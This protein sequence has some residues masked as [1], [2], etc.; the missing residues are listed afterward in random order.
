MAELRFPVRVRYGNG[1]GHVLFFQR[2]PRPDDIQKVL[3]SQFGVRDAKALQLTHNRSPLEK[4]MIKPGLEVDVVF[5]D[6]I[7]VTF[8]VVGWPEAFSYFFW[9]TATVTQ[10]RDFLATVHFLCPP[11]RLALLSPMPLQPARVLASLG[12]SAAVTV[13]AATP[14]FPVRFRYRD[15]RFDS[16]PIIIPLWCSHSDRFERCATALGSV[17]GVDAAFLKITDPNQ[18]LMYPAD[19]VEGNAAGSREPF[20]FRIVSNQVYYRIP[21]SRGFGKFRTES[22]KY[23]ELITCSRARVDWAAKLKVSDPLQLQLTFRGAPVLDRDNLALLESSESDPIVVTILTN[24][25]FQIGDESIWMCFSDHDTV[26]FV[27][28]SLTQQTKRPLQGLSGWLRGTKPPRDPQ[29]LLPDQAMEVVDPTRPIIAQ[30]RRGNAAPS[31]LEL[32][33]GDSKFLIQFDRDVVSHDDL[34]GAVW[35]DF[36]LPDPDLKLLHD[37]RK[38]QNRSRIVLDGTGPGPS[39]VL[40]IKGGVMQK[41]RMREKDTGNDITVDPMDLTATVADLLAL[42]PDRS[43]TFSCRGK[44]IFN[45]PGDLLSAYVRCADCIDV[46]FGQPPAPPETP[47]ATPEDSAPRPAASQDSTQR[48]PAPE[49]SAPSSPASQDLQALLSVSQGFDRL[50]ISTQG[51]DPLLT[52]TQDS[53]PSATE[54]EDSAP[55]DSAR[56]PAA[57]QDSTHRL[58]APDDSAPSPPASQDF[59]ALLTVSP[60][61]DPR[62]A[63]QKDSVP[64]GPAPQDSEWR[65]PEPQSIR[66]SLVL[67]PDDSLLEVDF[68]A[69]ATVSNAIDLALAVFHGQSALCRIEDSDGA[70]LDPGLL[71]ASIPDPRDLFVIVDV[72]RFEIQSRGASASSSAT[73][74]AAATAGDL[75]RA[76]AA[77]YPGYKYADPFGLILAAD[78]VLAG[79][80]QVVIAVP[81]GSQGSIRVRLF[82]AD[83]REMPVDL[84]AA[85]QGFLESLCGDAGL[86]LSDG[87]VVDGNGPV[88]A[89]AVLREV[90]GVLLCVNPATAQPISEE[91]PAAE[92]DGIESKFDRAE[93]RRSY[94]FVH[95]EEVFDMSIPDRAT[96]GDTKEFVAAKFKTFAENVKLLHCGK[97]LKDLLV[98]SKQR[99]RPPNRIIVYVR[100]MN[101][102]ILQSCG[103]GWFRT[104]E[105][106]PDYL[107]QLQKLA[108]ASGQDTRICSR[109][110]AYF[111]YD[112]GKALNELQELDR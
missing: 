5:P 95:D 35:R 74:P 91:P 79:L 106:P 98:L 87:V 94:T 75:E 47:Y 70:T 16:D 96:V 110:F 54:L 30:L 65:R 69:G 48:L 89:N 108:E 41:L 20:D 45:K 73:L 107:E 27:L 64:P 111:N 11:E 112:Y 61:F 34:L 53:G 49:D 32:T 80:G 25:Q 17:I 8:T 12:P 21:K 33:I 68:D 71:L 86:A 58:P 31:I 82:D 104:A 92:V 22:Q 50:L 2:D 56:R 85:A 40:E 43:P 3:Q 6:P 14:L 84:D 7:R 39:V 81:P 26:D 46:Q 105:K 62:P 38:M 37:S 93:P 1:P 102:I 100:E 44:T 15:T 51:F 9:R 83:V 55:Q 109:A 28:A 24:F 57:S 36:L 63:E 60:D 88:K 23:E 66:C 59:Q 19:D 72:C 67:P 18:N 52:A 90:V 101:S 99:I 4:K 29:L 42:L 13:R 97:E 77:K 76:F 10:L 78:R 103:V